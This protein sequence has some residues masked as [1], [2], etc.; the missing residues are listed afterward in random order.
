MPLGSANAKFSTGIA[1]MDVDCVGK[2]HLP[3]NELK[4]M[5]FPTQE[6]GVGAVDGKEDILVHGNVFIS[7][8]RRPIG[9]GNDS[10]LSGRA[11]AI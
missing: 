4:S 10:P 8:H 2:S 11:Q 1:N 6:S 5:I 9:R 3:D 7:T